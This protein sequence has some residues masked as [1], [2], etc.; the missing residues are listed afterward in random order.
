MAETQKAPSRVLIT[1]TFR[2]SFPNLARPKAYQ[3]KGEPV[4]S[5]EMLFDPGDLEK[6]KMWDDGAG[7]FVDVDV[8]R[9]AAQLAKEYWPDMNVKDA[10]AHGGLAWPF[11]SGDKRIADRQAAG[12]KAGDHY[13]AKVIINAK[14]S[15]DYPPSLYYVEGKERKQIAR[16][17]DAGDKRAAQLFYGGAYAFAELT[18][19]P[20]AVQGKFLTFYVQS[21]RFVKDG[22]RFGGQS[23]MDRFEGVHGG[24]ADHDPTAGM[25]DDI[26]F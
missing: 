9:L 21:V 1:P 10:V 25:D 7:K 16:G 22:E 8:K 6:F 11:K 26:P 18:L 12:K 20:T 3:N 15:Q 2:M 14:S 17:T 13:A 4:Y 19:K 24:T 23:M 5:L